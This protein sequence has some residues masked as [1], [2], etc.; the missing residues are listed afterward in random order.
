MQNIE[1]PSDPVA[2]LIGAVCVVFM[3]L[4]VRWVMRLL[5]SLVWPIVCVTV[6]LVSILF[7][8][9]DNYY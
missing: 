2:L 5:L 3:W 7:L 1:L 8:L 6:V 4:A 9:K